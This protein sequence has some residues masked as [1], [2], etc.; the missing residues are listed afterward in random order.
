MDLEVRGLVERIHATQAMCTLSITGG[1]G[2]AISWLLGVPGASGTVLEV[3]VPYS[4]QSLNDFLGERPK[5]V[6]GVNTAELMAR[7]ALQ[8]AKILAPEARVLIGLG[9]TAAIAT[10]RTKKGDHGCFVSACT[11][12]ILITS[13][14]S[15]SK[16]QRD[17]DGEDKLVSLL[18]LRALA[19]AASVEFDLAVPMTNDERL[20]VQSSGDPVALLGAGVLDRVV[21]GVDNRVV[22]NEIVKGAVLAGSFDPLH[23]G[24]ER[25]AASA[26]K[27]L[28]LPVTFEISIT[29]VDKLPLEAAT[30]RK[31][32]DQFT[33][34]YDVVLTRAATFAEK[35]RILPGSTFVI[36]YDTAVRLF[37]PTYYEGKRSKM[38]D[39]L[40]TIRSA[41]CRFL[42]AGRL[43]R[44]VFRTLAD[45]RVPTGFGDMLNPIPPERFRIDVSS[46][47][48]RLAV[49]RLE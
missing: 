32:L 14:V 42:V 47:D 34:K 25:L 43:D 8:R 33:G 49:G 6:V 48:L 31:R 17:R 24:H 16:G 2:Q 13:G 1:G 7:E 29:N 45:I 40:S 35:A 46:T 10:D 28:G 41:D 38:I 12:D 15:F 22:E 11:D 3:L 4:S 44:G 36:G 27:I 19:Q 21:V 23:V 18:V 5:K 9:C 37:D 20:S 30:V 26:T 39:T